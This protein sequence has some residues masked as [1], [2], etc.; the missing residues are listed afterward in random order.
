MTDRVDSSHETPA[1]WALEPG[2]DPLLSG[3]LYLCRHHGRARSALTL[4]AGLP[5]QGGRLMPSLVTRA[6]RR[7]GLHAR[8]ARRPFSHIPGALLPCLLLLK[9]N[10]ACVLMGWNRDG[11]AEVVFPEQ[12]ND[13]LTLTD[14]ELAERYAGVAIYVRPKFLFD[15]RTSEQSQAKSEH[16]FWS[17]IF[18]ARHLYRDIFLLAF[19]LNL[20]A[21][22][23]PLFTMNVYDRVVPNHAFATLWVLALG[24]LLVLSFDYLLRNLRTWVL[25]LANKRIDNKLSARMMEQI[26]GMRLEHRPAS[27]G[28]F[29][30]NVRAF[31]AVRD[32]IA[33]ASVT[34]FI[35]VPFGIIFLV[36]LA[37]I[38]WPLVIPPLIG[39]LVITLHAWWSHQ[40]L[41]ELAEQTHR[42][43][44]QRSATLVEALSNLETLRAFNAAGQ[45][46]ARWETATRF[47][48]HING[49]IR[50]LSQRTV[51]FTMSWQQLTSVAV[52]ILG[53]YLL[54]EGEMT[55]GGLIA[56]M[57]LSARCLAPMGQVAALLTQLQQTRTSLQSLNTMMETPVERPADS[58]FI[59]R[60][61]FEGGIEF[62]HV[63]LRYPGTEQDALSELSFR[64]LPGERVGIIGRIG[65]GKSS[66]QRLI[67]GLYQPTTGSILIDGIDIRQ[68]DP[69]ELRRAIGYVPQDPGLVFGSLRDNITLGAPHASDAQVLSA[70]FRAGVADFANRHPSGF[71]MQVGERGE[72]LS[73]G[74]RQSVAIAR[75]LLLTPPLLLLDE[76]TSHMDF[77]SE[78]RLKRQLE[79]VISGHT[80]LVI[81]HRTALLDFVDR[82][83][84]LDNGKLIADGKK[85]EVLQALKE[86]RIK[87]ATS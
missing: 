28:S 68:L 50:S 35:D 21:L 6:A 30:N 12:S 75:A 13:V 71:A 60:E 39:I 80:V 36:V 20:L 46:Q 9:D 42:A 77:I 87:G 40:R 86:G 4:T 62:R 18:S 10:Q 83:L 70:A 33:T 26:L 31:E 43:G 56:S 41:A 63:S 81:T 15:R 22:T 59:S 11:L 38:S 69:V 61:R 3:L 57:M 8:L 29:A 53:V 65:S 64:I 37:V 25:E 72:G 51:A 2:S 47:L 82:L 74:Q 73:A 24:A 5:L 14:G 34:T 67:A 58:Q 17:A 78:E 44:A 7:A 45:I 19:V 16:W 1:S 79:P 27:V 55:Q 23:M 52:L 76:P 84:V 49:R 48:S 54:A 85:D 66:L 32:F